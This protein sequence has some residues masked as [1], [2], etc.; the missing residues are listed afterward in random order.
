MEELLSQLP[1]Y[2]IG[3]GL[4]KEDP[5]MAPPSLS[6]A[7]YLQGRCV[8]GC[9][10]RGVCEVVSFEVS[11]AMKI[12]IVIFWVRTLCCLMGG[13]QPGSW[14]QLCYSEKLGILL[15]GL[16][17]IPT[18]KIAIRWGTLFVS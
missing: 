4:N 10:Q 18:H 9:Q 15:E 7:L 14:R 8:T 1:E 3:Y 13:Y 11:I 17:E 12:Y 2:V 16:H 5:G 6:S